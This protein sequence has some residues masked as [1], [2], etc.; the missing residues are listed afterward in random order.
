MVTGTAADHHLGRA[1]RIARLIPRPIAAVAIVTITAGRKKANGSNVTPLVARS[2]SRTPTRS[3]TT[4]TT[5][6]ATPVLRVRQKRVSTIGRAHRCRCHEAS[7]LPPGEVAARCAIAW[8]QATASTL[9]EID[10]MPNRT[11]V[12]ANSGRV[13]GACPQSD[14][15]SPHLCAAVRIRSMASTT[16]GSNSS[17]SSAQSAESQSK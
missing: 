10:V 6:G 16:A 2:P 9:T 8:R 1:E 12:S 11:S 14:V 4:V 7:A 17:K 13:D 3:E 5:T 15:V